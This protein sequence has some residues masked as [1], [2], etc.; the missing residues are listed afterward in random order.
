LRTG[1]VGGFTFGCDVEFP[2]EHFCLSLGVNFFDF[3]ANS[4]GLGIGSFFFDQ[5]GIDVLAKRVLK[6]LDYSAFDF[7]HFML[8]THIVD[9]IFVG[10]ASG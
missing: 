5:V 4:L 2:L 3:R 6:S 9:H 10:V 7:E 8:M 1:C